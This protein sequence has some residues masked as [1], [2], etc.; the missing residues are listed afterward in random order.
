MPD[1]V[2]TSGVAHIFAAYGPAALPIIGLLLII[3]YLLDK[4]KQR[5]TKHAEEI[6]EERVKIQAERDKNEVLR[7]ELLDE[8]RG[9]ADLAEELKKTLQLMA[10][11]SP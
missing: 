2:M 10:S 6:K 8:A 3:K 7:K 5:E 11:R 9:N 4:D 1:E